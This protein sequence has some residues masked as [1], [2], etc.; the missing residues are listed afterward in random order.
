MIKDM[1]YLLDDNNVPYKVTLDEYAKSD[2]WTTNQ[3]RKTVGRD[4]LG[5]IL[6]STVFL[7]MNHDFFS[8]SPEPILFETMI[9][10]G[11]HDGYCVRATSW[12]KAE[13]I[14]K[15]ALELITPK[16]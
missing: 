3:E 8:E 5:D 16:N 15:Q 4:T 11:E 1:Y 2:M 9:F 13:E 14:H 10:G 12:E 6:V 7:G